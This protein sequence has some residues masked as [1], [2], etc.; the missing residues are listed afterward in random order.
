MANLQ[1]EEF[2]RKLA[3]ITEEALSEAYGQKMSFMLVIS[4]FGE[5]DKISDYIG[6]LQRKG[7]IEIL[8]TTADR[9]EKNQTIP[10]S[11]GSPQ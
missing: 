8:R 1:Q 4:P 2:L 10:A 7:S 9:L 11:Q 5:G 6:N 3:A